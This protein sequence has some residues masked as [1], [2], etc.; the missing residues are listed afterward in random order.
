M[1]RIGWIKDGEELDYVIKK[2]CGGGLND[3]VF[4]LILLSNKDRGIYLCI[5]IN[6]VGFV[7]KYLKFGNIY[8]KFI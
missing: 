6:V 7:L 4:I 1:Y 2:Y 8:K 3:S 5:V